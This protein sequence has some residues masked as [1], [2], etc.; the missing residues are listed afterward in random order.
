LEAPAL[1][2][3]SPG[4]VSAGA[5]S[6]PGPRWLPPARIPLASLAQPERSERPSDDRNGEEAN[7]TLR[8]D[9][10]DEEQARDREDERRDGPV[11][12]GEAV[13]LDPVERPERIAPRDAE[14][15]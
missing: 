3:R 15:A 6:F 9:C 10:E 1:Q 2:R 13:E 14:P 11:E 4:D 8:C 5:A 12:A 7:A